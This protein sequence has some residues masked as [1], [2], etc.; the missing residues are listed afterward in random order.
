MT[1]R[2]DRLCPPIRLDFGL[3][4]GS[5]HNSDRQL[6]LSRPTFAVVDP[7]VALCKA[8]FAVLTPFRCDFGTQVA[9]T[10]PPGPSISMVSLQRGTNITKTVFFKKSTKRST[11]RPQSE[12]KVVAEWPRGGP[13]V[14]QL[15]P[16]EL[17]AAPRE[18]SEA[19]F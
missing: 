5:F 15:G 19:P 2:L 6:T 17:Q 11:Q 3:R 16:T 13:K 18:T 1:G 14:S 8:T 9:P 10:W 12:P 4:C 7:Q